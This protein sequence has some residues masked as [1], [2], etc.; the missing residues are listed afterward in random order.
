[1]KIAIP[2]DDEKIINQHFGGAPNFLIVVIENKEIKDREI[3]KKP[4]HKDFM[5]NEDNPQ[6][7]DK[8]RHGF[9]SMASKRHEE[10][11][12]IIKDCELIITGRIGLGAYTDMKN[13][14][15]KIIATDVKEIDKAISLYLEGK[16]P[17]IEDRV[18]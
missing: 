13:S 18:C 6:I 9:G 12:K 3:R 11:K 1:M 17:H 5:E 14:G 16:L 10:I 7:D 8:G 2:I 15:I 4:G